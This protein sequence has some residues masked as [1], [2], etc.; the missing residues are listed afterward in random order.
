MTTQSEQALE[1]NLIEQLLKFDKYSRIKIKGKADL[2]ANLKTQ[3]EKHNHVT[4]SDKE[5]QKIL[6]ILNTGTVFERAKILRGIRHHIIKDDGKTFYF[7]FINQTEWCKNEFQV[8]NQVTIEGEYENRYDVTILIN[9]LPLV[10]IE[11]KRRGCEMGEA[12]RQI[13][14]YKDHSFASGSALFEYVQLF[15]ISNGVNTKYLANNR[16]RDLNFKQTFYWADEQN[17]KITHLSEFANVFL[18]PCHLSK[19]IC[20]YIVLAKTDKLLMV[21]RPYQYYAC[22]KLIDR[23]K[24]TDKNGYIWHTTGSGKTLT[25]FKASQ[26]LMHMPE[27][28]KV[29]FVVDRRDLDYQTTK[30]FN[31]FSEGSVDGT[32]NTKALV[33]QFGDD[34][35][36]LVT[37]IQKLN[38]AIGSQRYTSTMET[39]KDK[40]IVFIFDECH[41][42]QFGETHQRIVKYFNNHQMFGFTGTPIFADNAVKNQLGERTTKELFGDCL[43][44]YVITD[45][46]RDENVLSFSIEYV[47]KYTEKNT[48][49]YIDIEVEAIDERE[50][51]DNEERLN[52]ITDYIIH[53]H[54]TKTHSKQFTAMFAVSGIATLIKYYELF[55]A[56]EKEHK[57]KVATIFSYSANEE[58]DAVDGITFFNEEGAIEDTPNSKHS[59]EKLDEFIADYNK[60]F[61]TKFSTKDSQSYYDYYNEIAKRVKNREIDILIVVN[62][63]LTGFDSKPLNTLYVDRNL[64]H[65]GLIQAFSRT[66]R[67]LNKNKSHGN[68]VSFRNLKKATDEA[69][70]L[71]SN[72]D[73]KETILL[74]PYQN[75]L[76]D[77]NE[78]V[79]ELKQIAPTVDSVNNLLTESDELKFVEA[80]RNLMRIQNKLSCFA[81]FS[82]KDL[83]M[84]EQ[85]FKDYKSKYLDIYDKV[86][87]NN[88]KEK[89]SVLDDVD[90]EL[91][92][93]HKDVINVDYIIQ[94]LSQLVEAKDKNYENQKKQ[95]LDTLSGDLNLRSRK[96][97]IE[98]FIEENLV[99]IENSQNV[100]DEFKSYWD[101][102]KEK[103][104]ND[105]CDEESLDTSQIKDIVEEYLFANQVPDMRD[106]IMKS[107]LKKETLLMRQ[108]TIPRV[109]DKIMNFVNTFIEGMPA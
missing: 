49:N 108:K 21:L 16:K 101:K 58:N 68:I 59:R 106:K 74:K 85:E 93:V 78:A 67:I 82:F 60:M 104:F 84:S 13:L 103:A 36:L 89:V 51:F 75:Y 9:G 62:M 57:L 24:N 97:L 10:Q 53:N 96:A 66:N 29:V 45:A 31:N 7:E 54:A 38:N 34:T 70:A 91:E 14:R 56:K 43:H 25:S 39:L 44:K 64:K 33:K 48:R 98:Q 47:G 2:R 95:I 17:N 52:K 46:I 71:F 55:K 20:K 32:D 35:K 72:K 99:G 15:I 105:L 92:L 63:F 28:H 23:V 61:G 40:R 3:L 102:Q 76:S 79:E 109:K 81:D 107:M 27:V 90:F 88:D 42:S 19:M 41:R 83:Q 86:N 18:E 12:H 65:H 69:I 22:E 8:T 50:L 73:A 77:F 30:E 37:T 87:R 11:L 6:P 100:A 5:F 1:N 4:L 26:I 80:F 94:L